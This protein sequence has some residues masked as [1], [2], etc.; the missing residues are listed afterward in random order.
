MRKE[1][2]SDSLKES[3]FDFFIGFQGL[4]LHLKKTIY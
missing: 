2:I 1:D 3:A 4:S